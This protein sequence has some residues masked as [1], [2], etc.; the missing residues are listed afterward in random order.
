MG[1]KQ[2]FISLAT[3]GVGYN[4]GCLAAL[5]HETHIFKRFYA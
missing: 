5:F 4:N 1:Q 2:N 3:R